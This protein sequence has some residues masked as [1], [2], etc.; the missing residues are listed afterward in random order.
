MHG[1]GAIAQLWGRSR[2]ED[3]MNQMYGR[4]NPEGVEAVTDTAL[5]YRLLSKYTAFVAV[6]EEVR[7]DPNEDKRSE[8]VPEPSEILGNLLAILFLALFFTR[9]RW[10]QL[11]NVLLRK[12]SK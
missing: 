8:A 2:I 6:T 9:K 7:V 3:L 11:A 4:E 12:L 5:N 10:Y 1:N